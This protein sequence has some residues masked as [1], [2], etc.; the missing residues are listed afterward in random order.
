MVTLGDSL[1]FAYEAEFCNEIDIP[2]GPDYGDGFSSRVRNWA[3]ILYKPG[4]RRSSFDLGPRQFINIDFPGANDFDFFL[5]NRYN[6]ALP[7]LKIDQLWKFM[8][9]DADVEAMVGPDLSRLLEYTDFDEADDFAVGDLEDQIRNTAERVVIFIGGNDVRG[10]YPAIY[11]RDKPGNFVDNFVLN[12]TRIVDRVLELNPNVQVVL[13]NVPHVGITPEVRSKWP[14]DKVKTERVSRVLRDLN[15]RLEELA[16]SKDIGYAD[17]YTSTVSLLRR[18]P[19]CIQGVA[20]ENDGSRTANA[21]FVWLNGPLSANFHPN[22]NLQALIAN[23][24]I[25][26][27]NVRYDTGIAPL[28]ATEILVGLLGKKPEQIDM[29]FAKWMSNY[30]KGGLPRTDDSDGDGIPASVEFATGLNPKLRDSELIK[31]VVRGD[32]RDFSYPI[33]LPDSKYFT[34]RALYAASPVSQTTPIKPNPTTEKDGL[35]HVRLPVTDPGT[36]ELRATI[37][38]K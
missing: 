21:N 12:A 11:N 34:L 13:V 36:L 5:R 7:G 33:R 14:T 23:H 32:T 30:G 9:R 8:N 16:K 28:S 37:R 6:W 4:Y 19:Y 35:A 18:A 25:D 38:Y 27:F 29:T 22:T 2:F 31:T 3:E 15:S 26:A 17:L 1:T 24:I 10:V 20:F